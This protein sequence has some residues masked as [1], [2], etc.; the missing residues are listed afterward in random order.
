MEGQTF[1]VT[2]PPLFNPT[3][4]LSTTTTTTLT[5]TSSSLIPTQTP[6]TLPS[7]TTE[8]S[9]SS[10]SLYSSTV[11]AFSGLSTAS[12]PTT[13]TKTI[14]LPSCS[15]LTSDLKEILPQTVT[16]NLSPSEKTSPTSTSKQI[17]HYIVIVILP[18]NIL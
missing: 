15:T 6:T 11:S 5:L 9:S 13:P 18:L 2:V 1:P 8:S 12:Q 14:P 7:L 17:T 4:S 10:S 3:P 16:S